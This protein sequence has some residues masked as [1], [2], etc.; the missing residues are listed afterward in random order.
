M[1]HDER[2]FIH[3]LSN[4]ISIA[5]GNLRLIT[6]RWEENPNESPSPEMLGQMEKVMENFE[7]IVELV[8]ERRRALQQNASNI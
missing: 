2:K 1:H 4:P 3:D 7:K 5:L 6:K 8:A